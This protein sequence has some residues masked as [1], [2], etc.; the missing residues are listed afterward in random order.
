[1]AMAPAQAAVYAQ[2]L[3][4]AENVETR[5]DP[6]DSTDTHPAPSD[7]E[8][9]KYVEELLREVSPEQWQQIQD[10]I[11]TINK[12][13]RGLAAGRNGGARATALAA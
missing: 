4:P 5:N 10:I 11:V 8:V 1:M 12:K 2:T 9:T 6:I 13:Q 3:H 7:A